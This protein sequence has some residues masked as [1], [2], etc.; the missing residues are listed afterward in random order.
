V[1]LAADIQRAGTSIAETQTRF[2]WLKRR[3]Q[4]VP[5]TAARLKDHAAVNEDRP[6]PFVAEVAIEWTEADEGP[7]PGIDPGLVFRA[8]APLTGNVFVT[9]GYH[10]VQFSDIGLTV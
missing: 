10:D 4:V 2:E 9:G 1:E 3:V 6:L 5:L 8:R 7:V